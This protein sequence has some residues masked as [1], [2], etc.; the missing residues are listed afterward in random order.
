MFTRGL[1]DNNLRPRVTVCRSLLGATTCVPRDSPDPQFILPP[2]NGWPN[3]VSQP[4]LGRHAESL[5]HGVPRKLGQESALGRVLIQQQL[6]GE[7]KNGTI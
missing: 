2:T 4:D 3:R 5:C 7:Y 6:P 1:K